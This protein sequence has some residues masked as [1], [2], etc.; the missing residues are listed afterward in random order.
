VRVVVPGE[1]R[2]QDFDS[3]NLPVVFA[4]G[5]YRWSILGLDPWVDTACVRKTRRI[6]I[7][8]SLLSLPSEAEGPGARTWLRRI[9]SDGGRP[10]VSIRSQGRPTFETRFG[11]R[12]GHGFA[13]P[14]ATG[15]PQ[16][17]KPQISKLSP[18]P[19]RRDCLPRRPH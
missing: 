3:G 14:C 17:S 6:K 10:G 1:F 16:T 15:R 19:V 12:A 5:V 2:T 11:G 7:I 8:A 9:W 18:P 13:W 4:Y